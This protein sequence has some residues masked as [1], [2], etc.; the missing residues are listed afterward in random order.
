MNIIEI[1]STDVIRHW[2]AW[3]YTADTPDE[4]ID[5]DAERIKLFEAWLQEL[6][7]SIWSEETIAGFHDA[8]YSEFTPNP[9][10][11]QND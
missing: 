3:T 2:I 7:A 1:P 11:E 8:I 4:Y 6:K 10:E 9:Y 5:H